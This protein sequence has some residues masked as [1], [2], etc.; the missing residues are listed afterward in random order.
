MPA[1][2][3]H[4]RFGK[5]ALS[6]LPDDIRKSILRFRRLYDVGLHGPDIFFYYNPFWKTAAGELGHQF[7]AM[8]GQEFFAQAAQAAATEA[9]RV[10]LYGLL[11]HYCLDSACH[12]YVNKAEES[13]EARHVELESEFDRYLLDCDGLKPPH[14]QDLSPHIKLTRGECVTVA[15]FYP[16]ATPGQ[17]NAAVRHM[18]WA[19]RFFS[20]KKRRRVERLVKLTKSQLIADH[21]LPTRADARWKV[22]DSQM[23]VYYNR[24]LNSYP[25]L[26]KRLIQSMNT[27]ASLGE[28]FSQTFG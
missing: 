24:A 8:T 11:A 1:G 4:Y 12:P 13:G 2:Y 6:A 10:Y 7:H 17:I 18:A 3:A 20:G 28:E 23:L 9:G 16:P 25:Q 15:A 14:T 19:A 27:D 22:M 26:L 21:L 5:Q